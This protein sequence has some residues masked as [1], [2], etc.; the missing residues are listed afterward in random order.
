MAAS[1]HRARAVARSRRAD[2][3]RPT[4]AARRRRAVAARERA[5]RAA[6]RA[7]PLPRRGSLV[8]RARARRRMEVEWRR[9]PD[10]A[11][12][13]ARVERRARSSALRALLPAR[14]DSAPPRPALRRRAGR[15]ARLRAGGALRR[16]GVRGARRPRAPG[17]A[18]PRR[19]SLCRDRARDADAPFSRRSASA[20]T[21]A[22]ARARAEAGLAALEH[23]FA[24]RRV[25]PSARGRRPR[26]PASR[27]PALDAGAYAKAVDAILEQIAA[28]NVYQACFTQRVERAF[29]RRSRSRSTARCAAINPAPF[30]ACSSCRS[31]RWSA[32]RP[33]ASCASSA[34][35]RVES[36]PI[37]GTRPRGATPEEDARLRAELLRVAE[38]ARRER[39]DRRPRAQRPRP[40]LR[41]RQR[42]RARALRGREPTPRCSSWSRRCA[43]GSRAGATPS[44]PRAPASRP[45][46]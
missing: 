39:D 37:K 2:P 13:T 32:P 17:C 4:R 28:G 35:G 19:R 33:S 22:S 3:L 30:A 14:R 34:D 27:T 1:R 46:R 7:L 38:G 42:P 6:P 36:R 45:A 29:A 20:T 26:A 43:G 31:S 23:A 12:A 9:A 8:H 11:L 18:V 15:L 24:R 16:A 41:D 25:A 21:T 40:R 44:T 5:A 10:G